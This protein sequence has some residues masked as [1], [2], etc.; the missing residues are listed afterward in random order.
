MHRI[1]CIYGCVPS[2][3]LG[4]TS[5]NGPRPGGGEIWVEGPLQ[6]VYGPILII[7]TS[8]SSRTYLY[9][10]KFYCP[11]S[12]D[13]CPSQLSSSVESSSVNVVRGLGG[14]LGAAPALTE[15]RALHGTLRPVTPEEP[16]M[17]AS[18]AE[19][20]MR[21]SARELLPSSPSS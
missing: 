2:I 17:Q 11:S 21:R 10:S 8:S 6:Y 14:G 3:V 1:S 7:V 4:F 12:T 5:C 20:I 18:T 9:A 19:F 16:P 15:S 13:H